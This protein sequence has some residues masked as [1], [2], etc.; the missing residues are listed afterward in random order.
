MKNNKLFF[1]AALLGTVLAGCQKVS[2]IQNPEQNPNSENGWTL[3]VQVSKDAGT[4]ALDYDG[5]ANTL[6]AY[7]AKGEKVDVYLVGGT[8]LGTLEVITD[9]DVE[10]ATISGQISVEGV[11]AESELM[12]VYPGG[13][14]ASWSYAGQEGIA[15]DEA[16]DYA[17]A[18]VSVAS[19]DA[20]T[21]TVAITPST[22]GTKFANEQSVYRFGFREDGNLL[23]VLSFIVASDEGKL[24]LNR[25]F[26]GDW[27]S[28][29][30]M[31]FVA[32]SSFTTDGRYFASIRN[33]NTT[34]T[35]RYTFSIVGEN[36]VLYVGEKVIN[37]ALANGKLY[38]ATVNVEG[39]HTAPGEETIDSAD[40][41]L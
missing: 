25:A 36:H 40:E 39:F 37:K 21:Q 20:T 15:P 28:E 27:T 16:F 4:R 9:D 26:G 29:Y 2:E 1:M 30:G 13:E 5:S 41:V 32:P 38:N 12:L 10:P 24:V 11:A 35:N 17:T 14:D 23:D 3:T 19:L 6:H 22:T 7:W 31:L 33:E 34:T 18:T 8:K